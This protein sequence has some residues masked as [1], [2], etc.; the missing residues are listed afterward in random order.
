[1]AYYKVT[2]AGKPSRKSP[3]ST[4]MI[5]TGIVVFVFLILH[6]KTFKFGPDIA[7][8]YVV[9]ISGESMRDLYRLV[10]EV[11]SNKWY[12]LW[13]V[14]AMIPLGLHLSHGFWSA[15]QSLGAYHPRYTPVL[16]A[17]GY[18]FAVAIAGGF[19]IIPLWIYFRGVP[20]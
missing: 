19:L 13:Y 11:F 14:M 10:V 8:G 9:Q 15:F 20:P 6:L 1:V 3:G 16:Y 12:V 5:Y 18:A 7:D 2:G 17:A 4:T